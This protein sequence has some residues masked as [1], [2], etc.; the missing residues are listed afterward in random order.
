[1]ASIN[2]SEDD[3]TTVAMAAN[4]AKFNGDMEAARALDKIARKINAAL[5]GAEPILKRTAL[6][7]GKRAPVRW[8]DMPSTIGEDV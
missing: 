1:M 4:D 6:I 5:T 2:I 3:F 8:Q 7:T